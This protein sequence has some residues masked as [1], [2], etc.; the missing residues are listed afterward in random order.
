VPTRRRII[1]R[2]RRADKKTTR[3]L[4]A[5]G[6]Q[7]YLNLRGARRERPGRAS[8]LVLPAAAPQPLRAVISRSAGGTASMG[9]FPAAYLSARQGGVPSLRGQGAGLLVSFGLFTITVRKGHTYHFAAR[10]S[11][12]PFRDEPENYIKEYRNQEEEE[13]IEPQRQQS[14]EKASGSITRRGAKPSLFCCLPLCLCYLCWFKRFGH[15]TFRCLAIS[16]RSIRTAPGR[17]LF[18][19]LSGA[20]SVGADRAAALVI[21]VR[22]TFSS[23][24]PLPT[25]CKKKKKKKKH[26][27]PRRR[28]APICSS[29]LSSTSGRSLGR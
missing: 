15:S 3:L 2:R 16:S 29:C 9:D 24:C 21:T 8:G 12:T 5:A 13:W 1:S 14:T 23:L 10:A 27:P 22:R 7:E 20:R 11:A 25:S 17:S 4:R 6:E 28:L 18:L 19:E 26:A